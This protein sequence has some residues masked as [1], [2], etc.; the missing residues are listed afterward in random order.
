MP[1]SPARF[2]WLTLTC[3]KL[4]P[5]PPGWPGASSQSSPSPHAS[6]GHGFLLQ[7][8]V[9]VSKSLLYVHLCVRVGLRK[10]RDLIHADSPEHSRPSSVPT[11]LVLGS[12]GCWAFYRH[13]LWSSSNIR[14]VRYLAEATELVKSKPNWDSN[15]ALPKAPPSLLF[16][17]V[18]KVL[19]GTAGSISIK[20][21]FSVLSWSISCMF[22][23]TSHTANPVGLQIIE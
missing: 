11:L 22:T 8:P 1:S 10:G 19:P 15:L 7:S 9:Y 20:T 14:G 12:Y 16:S 23:G 18:L 4:P 5:P 21:V 2:T 13:P 17:P 6:L 3:A